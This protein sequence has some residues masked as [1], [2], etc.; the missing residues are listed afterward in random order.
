MSQFKDYYAILKVMR[1][2]TVSEIVAAYKKQCKEWHPDRNPGIDTTQ[3]MQEINEAKWILLNPVLRE[4]Y[5]REYVQN[6]DKSSRQNEKS[7]TE[8]ENQTSRQ[9]QSKRNN[10]R[11]SKLKRRVELFIVKEQ[12]LY[13]SYQ[14]QIVS[15]SNSELIT[16]CQSWFSYQ[17]EFIDLVIVELHEKRTYELYFIYQRIKKEHVSGSINAKSSK[18]LWDYWIIRYL[19]WCLI[20]ALLHGTK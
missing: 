5:D 17:V 11:Y 8:R 20:C 13:N 16:I 6:K 4:K 9:E 7:H 3:I 10:Q 18:S 2:A 1:N 15:K 12:F 14:N 19:I